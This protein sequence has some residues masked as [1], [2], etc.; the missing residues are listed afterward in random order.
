MFPIILASQW[1]LFRCVFLTVIRAVDCSA[2]L[3]H[4]ITRFPCLFTF[5]ALL[6]LWNTKFHFMC[7]II[8]LYEIP[9]IQEA[10]VW[11]RCLVV[12]LHPPSTM[13]TEK[14][15]VASRDRDTSDVN[16]SKKFSTSVGWGL[17]T[18]MCLCYSIWHAVP[19]HSPVIIPDWSLY[20]FDVDRQIIDFHCHVNTS[21]SLI[22]PKKM[23]FSSLY[24]PLG[25]LK[26]ITN[27][28][29]AS[30]WKF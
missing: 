6:K 11:D 5:S 13:I 26:K 27:V 30:I 20:L 9:L 16:N 15:K 4:S 8:I 17:I 14:G 3:Q 7:N 28:I 22:L 18:A 24:S 29:S 2:L 25:V 21:S 12:F 1:S 23:S 19:N 10:S